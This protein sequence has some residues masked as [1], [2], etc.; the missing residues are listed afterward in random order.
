MGGSYLL[1]E[2]MDRR[3]HDDRASVG[4]QPNLTDRQE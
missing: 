4:W 1:A 2:Y 3:A